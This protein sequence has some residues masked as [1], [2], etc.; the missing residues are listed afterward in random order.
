MCISNNNNK[1]VKDFPLGGKRNERELERRTREL[2]ILAQLGGDLEELWDIETIEA[3]ENS[4]DLTIVGLSN[5][6][7]LTSVPFLTPAP[8]GF[9][10]ITIEPLNH[11]VL[12]SEDY[13]VVCM[14]SLLGELNLTSPNNE[15]LYAAGPLP[16]EEAFNW[17]E[18]NAENC[19]FR[20]FYL[21]VINTLLILKE[22]RQRK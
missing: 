4:I 2:R 1:I 5:K 8:T 20:H 3:N 7:T 6:I 10:I 9:N 13:H 21:N 12:Y 14:S 17:L 11:G 18:D 16:L 19:I 15:A 22:L